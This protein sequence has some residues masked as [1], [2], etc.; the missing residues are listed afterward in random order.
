[1]RQFDV[2]VNPSSRSRSAYPLV[3]LMQ[4]EWAGDGHEQ[5]I[6][7]LARGAEF[8]GSGRLAPVVVLNDCAYAALMPALAVIP[9]RLLRTLMGSL[10]S[11]RQ[12][13][14]AAIDYL[15]FGI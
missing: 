11:D 13:L 6:A 10:A 9:S 8:P 1:M 3:V 14:L 2:Y 5:I 15:F 7:P 4:S 12:A